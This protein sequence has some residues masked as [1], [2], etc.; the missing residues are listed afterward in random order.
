MKITIITPDSSQDFNHEGFPIFLAGPLGGTRDWRTELV[1]ILESKNNTN[2]DE[3]IIFSPENKH[4]ETVAKQAQ[5]ETDH[6]NYAF[7]HGF[8]VFYL[9]DQTKYDSKRGYARTTRFELG[10]WLAKY[11][12]LPTWIRFNSPVIGIESNFE[13]IEYIKYRIETDYDVEEIHN[14][15]EDLATEI[16][17]K[18]S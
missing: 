15:L 3:L 1:T 12:Q 16:I 14:N 4:F 13:G 6:L 11:E 5:W 18:L 8:I 2:I 9:S 7:T 10:E 17:N